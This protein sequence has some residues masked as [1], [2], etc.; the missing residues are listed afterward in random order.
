M[1]G[2]VEGSGA[3]QTQNCI[4]YSICVLDIWG[5]LNSKMSIVK[6][7][8]LYYTYIEMF[9]EFN[10]GDLQVNIVSSNDD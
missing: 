2:P 9:I 7:I 6:Y 10:D 5:H 8:H 4:Y 3:A 1:R